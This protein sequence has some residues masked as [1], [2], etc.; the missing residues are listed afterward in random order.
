MFVSVHVL[1]VF[2]FFHEFSFYDPRRLQI[3]SFLLPL[4]LNLIWVLFNVAFGGVINLFSSTFMADLSPLCVC[5]ILNFQFMW[6]SNLLVLAQEGYYCL[7]YGFVFV[8]F[9]C[10][11]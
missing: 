1:Q 11:L 3:L 9:I 8:G 5:K 6:V 10:G 7:S 4:L 2:C